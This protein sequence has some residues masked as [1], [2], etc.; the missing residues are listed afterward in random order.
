MSFRIGVTVLIDHDGNA[1]QSYNF[2]V[3]RILGNLQKVLKFLNTYEVDEIHA[4]VLYKGKSVN[5]SFKIFSNLSNISISTPLGIGGGIT[6][7][8]IQEITQD[9]FFERCIFNS[10][11]FNNPQLLQKTKSIM[12][13]QSMVASIPFIINDKT[14]MIYN[15]ENDGFQAIGDELYKEISNSFNEIIL[16]DANSEGSKKG[17]NFEVFN[18]IE[19]PIDRVLISGGLTKNDIKKAKKMGLAGVSIDNFVLHSEYSIKGLR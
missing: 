16:L 4:I 13:H 18:Y 12:G 11:I 8:N 3:K 6:T 5:N 15:S 10:A 14:L 17:F 9:P 2:K 1:V 19:F 7:E